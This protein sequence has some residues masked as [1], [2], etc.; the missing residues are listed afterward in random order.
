MTDEEPTGD[1]WRTMNEMIGVVREATVQID[2]DREANEKR[3]KSSVRK[4]RLTW[5]VGAVGVVL[6]LVAWWAAD[7]AQEA[8]DLLRSQRT[9]ARV[10]ACEKDNEIAG[11]INALNDRTQDLLRVAAAPNDSRTAS[12]QE[13]TDRLLADE[14]A[15]YEA[16]KV[17][18]LDCS[19][20]AVER[21]Y[22]RQARG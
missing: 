4:V 10:A 7:E 12:Q 17:P 9:V 13:R 22:E 3:I 21:F 15:K 1:H 6:A 18:L 20:E 5:I 16:V 8:A 19:P 14:L 11:K 2:K